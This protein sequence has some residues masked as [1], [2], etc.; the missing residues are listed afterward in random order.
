MALLVCGDGSARRDEKA[1]GHFSPAAAAFDERIDAALGGGNPTALLTVRPDEAAALWVGGRPAWQV[2]AGA[3][4]VGRWDA[5][6]TYAAEPYGVHYI[7]ATWLAAE[8]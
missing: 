5:E 7:V 4:E 2:L 6:I 8:G 3:A 1:P